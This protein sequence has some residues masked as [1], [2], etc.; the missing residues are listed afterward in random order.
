MAGWSP[1]TPQAN[2]PGSGSADFSSALSDRVKELIPPRP[3]L[4]TQT[5]GAKKV[6]VRACDLTPHPALRVFIV[7]PQQHGM[8]FEEVKGAGPQRW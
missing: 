8:R 6:H 1:H 7:S 3:A 4:P 5:E 2:I